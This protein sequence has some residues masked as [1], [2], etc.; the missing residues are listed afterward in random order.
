MGIKVPDHI[1][2]EEVF[3]T[4]MKERKEKDLYI[5]DTLYLYALDKAN[6]IRQ[7]ETGESYDFESKEWKEMCV[8]IDKTQE[9]WD[10]WVKLLRNIC[11]GLALNPSKENAKRHIKIWQ[12]MTFNITTEG[13]EIK[14]PKFINTTGLRLLQTYIPHT[15][16]MYLENL[17][18]KQ[19]DAYAYIYNWWEKNKPSTKG[20]PNS[21]D[22]VKNE[23]DPLHSFKWLSE[24][25][26]KIDEYYN[27]FKGE[28]IDS[29]TSLE[30]F[31]DLFTPY[32][33]KTS[34]T[35]INWLYSQRE[36]RY[37]IDRYLI[38]SNLI[39]D[40]NINF[41]IADQFTFKGKKI[42]SKQAADSK[43]WMDTVGEYPNI[44]RLI[45]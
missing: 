36:L 23:I 32:K 14:N 34:T 7:F 5:D 31:R 12:R 28:C 40:R 9:Y 37:F 2:P 18:F 6:I 13:A 30:R 17:M 15:I 41:V 21:L 24:D 3:E 1:D 22:D 44:D 27:K 26:T 45:K 43:K 16:L 19:T 35:P 20:L 38:D 11:L 8:R 42:T 29:N 25:M 33:S 39:L 4:L 10:E